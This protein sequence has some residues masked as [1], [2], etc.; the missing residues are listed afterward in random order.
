MQI[1]IVPTNP[2]GN[3][4]DCLGGVCMI[5]C[6][7]MAKQTNAFCQGEIGKSGNTDAICS[8][9]TGGSFDVC[10]YPTG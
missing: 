4:Y 1:P 7:A 10:T 6:T 9:N 3:T 5:D 2:D 8:T